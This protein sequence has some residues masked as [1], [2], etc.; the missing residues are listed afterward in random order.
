MLRIILKFFYLLLI[1]PSYH[2]VSATFENP[3]F[4]ID[5]ASNSTSVNNGILLIKNVNSMKK[6]INYDEI[7]RFADVTFGFAESNCTQSKA[8][9]LK[10]YY[11]MIINYITSNKNKSEIIFKSSWKSILYDYFFPTEKKTAEVLKWI[12]FDYAEKR[13]TY[14][15]A[16]TIYSRTVEEYE[17]T[18]LLVEAIQKELDTYL[19]TNRKNDIVSWCQN[20]DHVNNHINVRVMKWEK[21]IY[22]AQKI[23]DIPCQNI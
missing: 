21:N 19:Y 17:G 9:C 1:F 3:S 22:Y 18:E 4:I 7:S 23:W 6:I 11:D 15:I 20:V 14:L 8:A 12:S 16:Y 5:D 10:Q 2:L 13:T